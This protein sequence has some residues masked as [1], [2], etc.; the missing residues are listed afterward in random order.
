MN[1]WLSSFAIRPIRP[2]CPPYVAICPVTQ[3]DV[4]GLRLFFLRHS[5]SLMPISA[6]AKQDRESG[7]SRVAQHGNLE[8]GSRDSMGSDR[9]WGLTAHGNLDGP[10]V[11][12]V[13]GE[14]WE[15]ITIVVVLDSSVHFDRSDL[16]DK[17]IADIHIVPEWIN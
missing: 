13:A 14:S 17:V 5:K 1:K 16:R 10:N 7:W 15:R 11:L 8:T 6:R 2:L 9:R 12:N 3:D 4:Y